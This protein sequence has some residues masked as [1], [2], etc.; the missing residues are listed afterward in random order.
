MHTTSKK[1]DF[2]SIENSKLAIILA[3]R[4]QSNGIAKHSFRSI[5]S[6]PSYP[7]AT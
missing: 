4:T 2:F 3:Y 6:I 1:P 7:M 5:L